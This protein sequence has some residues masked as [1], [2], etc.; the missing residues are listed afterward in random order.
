MNDLEKQERIFD[1]LSEQALYGLGVEEQKELEDLLEL[2]PEWR[3][4]ESF[5]VTAAAINLSAVFAREDEMPAH[6]KAKILED[7]EK[8]FVAAEEKPQ[9]SRNETSARETVSAIASEAGFFEKIFKINWLGWAVAGAA[10]VALALN[11]WLTQ[12]KPIDTA[13]VPPT[14]TPTIEKPTIQQEREQLVAAGGD[15]V[16]TTWSDFDPKKPRGVE[17]DIVWSNSKQKGFIRFRGLPVNDKS[18][19]TYQLWIFD[20]A[21]NAKTPIDGGVF[22]I[23]KNGEIVIPIDAKINVQ[24]PTM[25]AITAEKPGGVVVSE[26]GKVMAIA[27]IAT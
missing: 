24:K 2:F 7:A 23:D 12:P 1:L 16:T 5:A 8:F 4:D 9:A 19:E 6:L 26:L 18:K 15:V 13:K 17:G 25:F 22:D 20:A 11:V 14:P 10:V 27:K 21:Q 3:N